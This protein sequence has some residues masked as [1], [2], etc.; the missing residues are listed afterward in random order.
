MRNAPYVHP[1]LD[2]ILH[3]GLTFPIGVYVY[4]QTRHGL[5]AYDIDGGSGQK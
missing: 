1:R 3:L 2:S 5:R 4:G